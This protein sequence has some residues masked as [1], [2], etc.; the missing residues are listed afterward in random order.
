MRERSSLSSPEEMLESVTRRKPTD[1]D[2]GS[3]RWTN[4]REIVGHLESTNQKMD[5]PEVQDLS[6]EG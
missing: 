4:A 5:T 2:E 6:S 3:K 1:V